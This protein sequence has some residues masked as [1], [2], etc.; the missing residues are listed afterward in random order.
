MGMNYVTW[1]LEMVE[2][3]IKAFYNKYMIYALEINYMNCS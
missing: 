3:D 1:T 2:D